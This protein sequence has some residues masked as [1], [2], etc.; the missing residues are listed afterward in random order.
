MLCEYK[1]EMNAMF[2][3]TFVCYLKLKGQFTQKV[4][5]P[6]VVGYQTVAGSL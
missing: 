1:C 4:I 5:H 6:K 3:K 2:L